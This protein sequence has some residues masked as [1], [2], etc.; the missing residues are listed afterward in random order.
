MPCSLVAVIK[1]VIFSLICNLGLVSDSIYYNGWDYEVFEGEGLV[2]RW[3]I[4]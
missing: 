1:P 3:S 4:P 2:V